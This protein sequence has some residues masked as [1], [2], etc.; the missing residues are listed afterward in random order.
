GDRVDLL[1]RQ[2]GRQSAV[3]DEGQLRLGVDARRRRT[4][5]AVLLLEVRLLELGALLGGGHGFGWTR[6]AR[7]PVGHARTS[8][9]LGA[10]ADRAVVLACS[11]GGAEPSALEERSGESFAPA[12]LVHLALQLGQAALVPEHMAC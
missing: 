5:L 8:S 9:A 12:E 3:V 11:G 6:A 4:E 1:L 2:V 7:R 10:G